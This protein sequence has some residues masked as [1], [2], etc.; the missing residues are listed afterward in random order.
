[1]IDTFPPT[2]IIALVA[3]VVFG[4]GTVKGSLGIGFPAVAMSILPI[5]IDPALGVAIMSI[6]I[7]V[8]NMQQFVT[9]PGWPGMVRR[10]LWAGG[11]LT[12]SVFIAAQ[13]LDHVPSRWIGALVGLSLC[14]FALSSLFRFELKVN[15]GKAWQLAV[16]ISAG[17]LGGISAVKAPV[18]IYTVALKLPR[19]EFIAVAGF[20]FCCGGVGLVG[21]LLT[22]AML[23]GVTA[24]LSAL[25]VLA[26]IAGF[27]V[28]TRIRRRLSN[29]M[30][31]ALL[32]WAMLLLGLRLVAVSL[33]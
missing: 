4:S 5:F 21:G 24:T 20:L 8:T 16:G 13:F 12:V 17:I 1:M 18:M 9:I 32:L 29:A 2:A 25:A 31:R 22:S 6:P 27:Q 11:S 14:A 33:F 28:G 15:E 30:F 3:A 7:F 19:D 26:G 23:N 10:F